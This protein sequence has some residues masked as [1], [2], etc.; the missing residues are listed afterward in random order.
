MLKW[1]MLAVVG[2]SFGSAGVAWGFTQQQQNAP[3]FYELRI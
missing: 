2:L 1:K 3:G